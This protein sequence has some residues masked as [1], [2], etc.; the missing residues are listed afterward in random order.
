MLKVILF[1]ACAV[2]FVYAPAIA[3]VLYGQF[4][5]ANEE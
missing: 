2:I 5:S 4:D 3:D 1:V